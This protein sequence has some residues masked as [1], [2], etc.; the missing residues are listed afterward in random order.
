MAEN[1]RFRE[2]RIPLLILADD[3]ALFP[4]LNTDLQLALGL[5]ITE[6]EAVTMRISTSMS[7]TLVLIWERVKWELCCPE[8]V[9]FKY[10]VPITQRCLDGSEQ[11]PQ[12]LVLDF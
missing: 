11:C 1:V 6:C 12:C 3:V 8:V 9:E 2:F 10:L 7:Q 4:L 5:T